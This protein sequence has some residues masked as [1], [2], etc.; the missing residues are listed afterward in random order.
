MVQNAYFNLQGHP[1][2]I[3]ISFINILG[4]VHIFAILKKEKPISD[5]TCEKF[6]QFSLKNGNL[7]DYQ[8][9]CL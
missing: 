7:F 5:E 9:I 4:L 2:V 6:R 3:Y 1:K 8:I